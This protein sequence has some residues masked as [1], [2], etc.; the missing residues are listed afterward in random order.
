MQPQH[1]GYKLWHQEKKKL[2]YFSFLVLGKLRGALGTLG[3]RELA[4]ERGG[5]LTNSVQ[6]PPGVK[7]GAWY[8]FIFVLGEKNHVYVK[9][10]I[11]HTFYNQNQKNLCTQLEK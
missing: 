10:C 6:H 8:S 3:P 11:S 4:S 5:G 1:P 2:K 7:A 9:T